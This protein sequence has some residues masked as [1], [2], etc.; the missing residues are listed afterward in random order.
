MSKIINEEKCK[1]IPDFNAYHVSESGR[2]YRTLSPVNQK[3]PKKEYNYIRENKIHFKKDNVS[4]HGRVSLID[5][6]GKLKNLCAAVL[7]AKA[8][9]LINSKSKFRNKNIGYKDGNR[10]NLHFSNLIIIDKKYPNSKLSHNDIKIIKKHIKSGD[11]LR[12]ISLLFN[13]SEMQIY[14]IKT[15]ENWGNG[16]R[17]IKAPIAPFFIESGHMRKY[18]ATFKSEKLKVKIKKPFS[19]KR[20]PNNPTENIIHGIVGGFKLSRTHTNIT[21]AKKS[22]KTLNN[23]FFAKYNVSK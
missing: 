14:R 15:G 10:Y 23:Y 11:S 4:S 8:F 5:E 1:I 18:I 3:K 7:V 2:V 13:V 6:K 16:K 17:K 12:K 22:L 20:N 19:I 21:R 9:K